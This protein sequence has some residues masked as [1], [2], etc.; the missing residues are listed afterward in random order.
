MEINGQMQSCEGSRLWELKLKDH[1]DDSKSY[2]KTYQATI[3]F[4]YLYDIHAEI[5]KHDFLR[6]TMA[7]CFYRNTT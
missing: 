5:S 4:D 6:D 2:W 7:P 1:G 3:E